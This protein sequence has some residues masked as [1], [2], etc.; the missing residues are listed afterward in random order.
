M[1]PVREMQIEIPSGDLSDEDK[2]MLAQA[3]YNLNAGGAA[4]AESVYKTNPPKISERVVDY[5][6]KVPGTRAHDVMKRTHLS[7]KDKDEGNDAWSPPL[8]D[9][10]IADLP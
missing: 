4:Y 8:P 2:L 3:A 1:L 5:G 7:V 10:M 9:H 6:S